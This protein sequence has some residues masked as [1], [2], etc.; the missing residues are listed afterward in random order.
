MNIGLAQILADPARNGVYRLASTAAV[1]LPALDGG[2]L[3]DKTALLAALGWALEFPDYYGANW[4]ALEECL[5][6]MSWRPGG[7]ALHIAHAGELDAEPL[8]MLIAVFS[9]AAAFWREQ[10]RPCSLFLSDLEDP[11]LPIAA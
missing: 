7:I 8:A 6:D 11:R 4:D 3:A 1:G 10:G 2:V 9:D 5:T